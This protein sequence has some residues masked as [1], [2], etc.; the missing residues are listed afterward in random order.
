VERAGELPLTADDVRSVAAGEL[1]DY[2]VP[3]RVVFVPDMPLTTSGKIDRRALATVTPAAV[4]SAE[5]FVAPR[6]PL[7]AVIAAV[8]R[9]RLGVERIGVYDDFFAAGGHS[10]V[11][12]HI[13]VA[14]Q[15]CYPTEEPIV[16]LLLQNPTIAGL[17]EAIAASPAA[18]PHIA[19]TAAVLE[20]LETEEAAAAGSI[21]EPRVS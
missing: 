17:A 15:A 2:M 14:L 9:R 1:P 11:A 19:N 21:A 6:T 13:A 5:E 7:E 12:S 18:Q 4:E 20:R 16:M 3:S 10:L 8:L